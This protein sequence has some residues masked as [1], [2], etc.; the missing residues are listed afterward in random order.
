MLSYEQIHSCLFSQNSTATQTGF[1]MWCFFFIPKSI[2][3]NIYGSN[4]KL[5]IILKFSDMFMLMVCKLNNYV[6]EPIYFTQC[7]DT[8]HI[9]NTCDKNHF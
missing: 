3:S 2:T 4:L 6:N 8:V 9:D 7:T 1:T 5:I